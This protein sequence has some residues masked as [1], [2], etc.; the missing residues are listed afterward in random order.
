[1][2]WGYISKQ[3]APQVFAQSVDLV[4]NDTLT[5]HANEDAARKVEGD[6]GAESVYS[7]SAD[8][9]G[10]DRRGAGPLDA[11]VYGRGA[12]EGF[13]V[14]ILTG[15]ILVCGAE[16]GDVLEVEIL[17]LAPRPSGNPA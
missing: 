4:T 10:V 2:H 12:G 1:V 15:P 7:W 8:T 17:D 13:G 3:R 11:S 14:Q 6:P 16:P 9:K 5:H